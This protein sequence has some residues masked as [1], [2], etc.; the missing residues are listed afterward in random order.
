MNV[1]D[2]KTAHLVGIGGIN[3][4]AVAKLLVHVGVR[5][6]GSDAA[7]NEQT[8]LLAKM[9][10]TIAI[11]QSAENVPS[12][13]DVLIYSS[14]V[15]ASNAEREEAR[16]RAIREVTNFEFLGEWFA[17][18]NVVLVCG[19]HGKSTTTAMLGVATVK[20]NL[21]PTI[22][23]G[24]KVPTLEHGNL[25]IGDSDLV[26]IEGDE[27]AKHF[28]AFRPS[29]VI[30]N[31]IELDHTD[32]FSSLADMIATFRELMSRVKDGG[33]V[34]ANVGNDHV[35]T[36]VR[37]IEIEQRL[38]VVRF[39]GNIES[40]WKVSHV[41]ENGTNAVTLHKGGLTYELVLR[42]PGAFNAIN[43]AGAALMAR[44]L[45]VPL[46]DI[47]DALASFTGI[48][49]RFEFLQEKNGVRI[50]SDYGHHPT[51][52]AATLEAAHELYPTHR[53][54]LCFQPHHRNRTKHLFLDFVPSFDL[55]DVLVLCEIYDVKG[56][57]SADD[58][59]ISSQD[60]VDT[61]IPHDAD[62]GVTRQ[63]EF[64][65]NPH[66]AIEQTMKIARSGDVVI[67]MGAGDIDGIARSSIA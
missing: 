37:E 35:A 66:A 26:I 22:I 54:V 64:A 44:E 33:L 56:R 57:D 10:V 45:G 61:I 29:A 62:R 24:S 53:I 6:S 50:Y 17:Q 13:C 9:G 34:V 51:A 36:L 12:A 48:W 49:R 18:Q 11:G 16:R 25:R 3:M 39:N 42:L 14:A 60:L 19:T 7:A 67:I 55:A 46:F 63:V 5:V 20:G 30:L 27:Y 47:A 32:V 38:R 28:L 4:S 43:A 1:R 21:D 8:D 15:P 40:D 52:V 65:P 41:M 59:D 2:I 31:N 58:S 23:V